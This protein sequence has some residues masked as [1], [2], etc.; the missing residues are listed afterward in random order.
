MS[1]QPV[2]GEHVQYHRPLSQKAVPEW[3]RDLCH[4]FKD[5]P[6]A[7][8]IGLLKVPKKAGSATK[9]G[10]NGTEREEEEREKE[11]ITTLMPHFIIVSLSLP[12]HPHCQCLTVYTAPPA[13]RLCYS[14][15]EDLQPLQRYGDA[16]VSRSMLPDEVSLPRLGLTPA[17][18]AHVFNWVTDC[19]PDAKAHSNVHSV[20][21]GCRCLLQAC[22]YLVVTARQRH[23][24]MLWISRLPGKLG[25]EW[26]KKS[27]AAEWGN[28]LESLQW[29]R[30]KVGIM[31]ALPLSVLLGWAVSGGEQTS[32]CIDDEEDVQRAR[33]RSDS[34]GA[35][36][37]EPGHFPP[38]P[39]I[40]AQA[41]GT[42]TSNQGVLALN[43]E[44]AHAALQSAFA[45][46]EI[47]RQCEWCLAGQVSS[48][49]QGKVP[50]KDGMRGAI[51]KPSPRGRLEGAVALLSD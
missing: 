6:R 35:P 40:G 50:R 48:G 20:C 15:A 16:D 45:R 10:G 34:H 46:R 5:T 47:A 12:A 18:S 36:G 31:E 21:I 28:S 41:E 4:M 32:C 29:S 49:T 11:L 44:I 42:R 25:V 24:R 8:A 27:S 51:P 33:Q 14:I 17:V 26:G 22:A 2:S 9:L 13:P 19:G 1:E 3:S 43:D 30:G 7:D 23:L 37:S 39:E 38:R